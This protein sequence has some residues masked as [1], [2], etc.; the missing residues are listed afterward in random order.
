MGEKEVFQK[1]KRFVYQNARPLDLARWRYHFEGGRAEEVLEILAMYQKE[2]GGFGYALE[3]DNWNPDSNPAATWMAVNVLREVNVTDRSHPM[4]QGILKYLDSGKDFAEGKWYNTVAANNEYPHA[5][6][7]SCPC[8][9][10]VPDDNPTVS[11]AGFLL[12]FAEENTPLHRK[13]CQIA[14]KAV[15]EF[16]EQPTEEMHTVKN[17]L[18][19]LLDCEEIQHFSLFDLEAF[20]E[21]VKGAVDSAICKEPEKWYREYVFKP[22]DFFE[23]KHRI[24]EIAG[25]ELCELQAD[26]ILEK[27]QADGSY[28]VTWQ[29][30]TEYKEYEISAN[31]WRAALALKHMCYLKAMGK[32]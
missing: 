12:R 26:M 17:F 19:L 32:I 31:W 21:K 28:P 3:P 22:V 8:E 7:W 1:A 10:G 16:M 11:L 2:D 23:P 25:R 13:A 5:V 24:F 30:W 15:S 20:R 27:Q 9:T 14:E 4:I 29:W 6:W 18:E